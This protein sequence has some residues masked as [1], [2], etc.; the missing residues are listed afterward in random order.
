[1]NDPTDYHEPR[2][3][4]GYCCPNCGGDVE[5]RGQWIGTGW[6]PDGYIC[7]TC[8]SEFDKLSELQED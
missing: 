8:D 3:P 2:Q 4:K 5:D 1:V 7:L 6:A